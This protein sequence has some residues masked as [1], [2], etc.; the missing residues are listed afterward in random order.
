MRLPRSLTA[1]PQSRLK[2]HTKDTSDFVDLTYFIDFDASQ[3]EDDD[4]FEYGWRLNGGVDNPLGT[5]NGGSNTGGSPAAG[6][7]DTDNGILP[8]GA[9]SA[10]FEFY[11]SVN[12]DGQANDAVEIKSIVIAGD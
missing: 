4:S 12:G 10:D 9:E 8:S 6:E 5:V 3:L 2:K 11:I 7:V 1:Q